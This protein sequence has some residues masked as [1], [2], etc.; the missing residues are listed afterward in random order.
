M[1]QS[2]ILKELATFLVSK[3]PLKFI[4]E[5]RTGISGRETGT[6]VSVTTDIVFIEFCTLIKIFKLGCC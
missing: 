2:M 1:Q 4:S 3:F 6:W 5:N